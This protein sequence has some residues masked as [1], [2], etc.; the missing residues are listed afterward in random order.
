LNIF[1]LGRK[2]IFGFVPGNFLF[3]LA[4]TFTAATGKWPSK[5][6]PRVVDRKNRQHYEGTH[7]G[8]HTKFSIENSGELIRQLCHRR[9]WRFANIASGEPTL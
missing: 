4:A 2:D 8:T 1:E 9:G 7:A 6:S 3:R 5:S